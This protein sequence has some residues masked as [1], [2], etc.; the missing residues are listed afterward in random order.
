M[1][2]YTLV[3]IDGFVKK[4]GQSSYKRDNKRKGVLTKALRLIYDGCLPSVQVTELIVHLKAVRHWPHYNDQYS[5]INT[6]AV[7]ESTP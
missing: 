3:L 1:F 2:R 7:G 4:G 5:N 6:L